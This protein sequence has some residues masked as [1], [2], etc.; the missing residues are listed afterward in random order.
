MNIPPNAAYPGVFVPGLTYPSQ[1]YPTISVVASQFQDDR[2]HRKER[3]AFPGI[4][5][6]S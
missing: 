1:P 5:R 6:A 4:S 2:R 3:R